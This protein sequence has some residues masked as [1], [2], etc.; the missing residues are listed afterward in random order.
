MVD[1]I[2][3]KVYKDGEQIIAQVQLLVSRFS[4]SLPRKNNFH[5]TYSLKP[6]TVYVILCQKKQNEPGI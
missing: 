1:V 3:T 5:S 2:G 4:S 6:C